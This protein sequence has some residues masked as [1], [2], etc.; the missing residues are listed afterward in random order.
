VV[1][2]VAK[3]EPTASEALY[4]FVGWLTT[5]DQMVCLSATQDAAKAAELVDLYVKTNDFTPPRD[6]FAN[7]VAHPLENEVQH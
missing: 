2:I 7:R 3:N 6:D 5:R 4:G 1:L